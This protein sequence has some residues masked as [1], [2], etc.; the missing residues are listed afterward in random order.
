LVI[1]AACNHV[2]TNDR[3][4]IPEPP[5]FDVP[6]RKVPVPAA[7]ACV[8]SRA[9]VMFGAEVLVYASGPCNHVLPL[10]AADPAPAPCDVWVDGGTI[11]MQ[12]YHE[13]DCEPCSDAG[14]LKPISC[15][16][17]PLPKGTYPVAIVGEPVRDGLFP[18][19]LVVNDDAEYTDFYCDP[20]KPRPVVENNY[21]Q[22]CSKDDDCFLAAFAADP[23][24]S[25]VCPNAALANPSANAYLAD[26][27]VATSACPSIGPQACAPCPPIQ[28]KCVAAD[29][30]YA[31]KCTIGP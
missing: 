21:E 30:G 16:V 18:R 10:Y 2:A 23:C 5:D 15:K 20:T 14:D 17:P 27:R 28:A 9:Q 19:A 24:A 29:G 3:Q 25:C 11:V 8:P 26:M 7:I 1:S 4:P 13:M 22:D 31:P 12:P 6:C